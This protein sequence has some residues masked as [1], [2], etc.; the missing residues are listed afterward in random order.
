MNAMTSLGTKEDLDSLMLNLART[1]AMG[2]YEV[3]E[4]LEMLEIPNHIFQ[5]IKTH[6]RFINYL[7]TE[8]EAWNAASNTAE[9]T[10][11][12]ASIV[13][14]QYMVQAYQ[15]LHAK[16]TPLNQRVELGKLLGQ[17]AGMTGP[18]NGGA[19]GGGAVPGGFHLQINIAPGSPPIN[20]QAEKIIEHQNEFDTDDA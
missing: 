15:D 10:K 4:I 14:E 17:I 7:K 5:R 13:L 9:R 19:G 20:I 6:P 3:E 16:T 8:K 1:I 18:K 11:L 12:K 2:M